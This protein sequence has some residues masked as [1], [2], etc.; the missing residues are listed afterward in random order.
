[1]PVTH[2]VAGSSPVRTAKRFDKLKQ[3]PEVQPLQGFFV[4]AM[5]KY[6][7]LEQ[8]ELDYSDNEYRTGQT[9]TGSVRKPGCI[10]SPVSRI[11]RTIWIV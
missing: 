7:S 4:Y 6:G 11:M 9:Y 5:A 3:I 8:S 10:H 2:G 1:M